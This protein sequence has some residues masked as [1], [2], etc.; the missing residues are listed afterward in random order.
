MYLTTAREIRS[1]SLT[2]RDFGLVQSAIP[3]AQGIAVDNED[4]FVF[5]AEKS[6]DKAGIFKSMLDGSAHQNVVSVGVETVEDLAVDWIGRHVYF[7]DSGRKHIVACDL[8]GTLCTVVISGQLGS[9]RAVAVYPENRLLFWTDWGSHPHIGSSG[10]DGSQRKEIISSSIAWPNGLVVDETIHRIFWSDGKLNRIESSRIDGSDRSVLAVTAYRPYSIDVFENTIYWTNPVD[11]EIHSCDKFNG[12]NHQL[13][14]KEASLTPTGIHINHPSK[15]RH[16]YNPCA[17][18]VCSHL[19][20]LSPGLQGFQCACPVGMQLNANNRTCDSGSQQPSVVIG[21]FTELYQI[22]HHQIGKESIIRLPTRETENIGALVFNPSG[23]SVIYSDLDR[24]VIFSMHLETQREKILFSD[25]S[26][27]E[28]L[29]VDPYTENVYWT[30]VERGILVVGKIDNGERLVLV[31]ELNS[32]KSV[33][34]APEKGLLFLVEGRISHVISSFHMDGGW[35]QELA[36]V[37]GTVSSM[38]YNNLN[39]YL[40]DSVRGTIERIGIDGRDRVILRS[41]LGSPIALGV[42]LESIFWLSQYSSR[43]NW[44][45]HKEPKATRGFIIDASDDYSVQYRKLAI[46][47]TYN[48]TEHVCMGHTGGCSDLC[49]PTPQGSRCLCPLGKELG[50]NKSVCQTA[51]CLGDQW[52]KC[53]NSC[54]PAQLRC[55]GIPD[56]SNGEDEERCGPANPTANATACGLYQ[57]AC[58]SGGCVP[59]SYVC[60]GDYDCHDHSDEPVTCP[61]KKC[62]VDEF[63]CSDGRHCVPRGVFCD[64]QRDCRDGS[65][66]PSNCSAQTRC[67]SSQ[68]HCKQ[69]RLCI[70]QIWVCDN[71]ADCEHAEDEQDCYDTHSKCPDNYIRCPSHADCLPRISLCSDGGMAGCQLLTDAQLC[72][73]AARN[74]SRDGRT[75]QDQV[76]VPPP[77]ETCPSNQFT[78]FL[79]TNECIPISQKCNC[80]FDCHFGEDE[81]GCAPCG[82]GLFRCPGEMRFINTSWV[83][84]GTPDCSSGADELPGLCKP[85]ERSVESRMAPEYDFCGENEFRCKSGQCISQNWTCDSSRDC[86]DGTDEGGKCGTACINNGKCPQVCV[87]GPDGPSCLCNPGFK[88]LD[89]GRQCEDIDECEENDPCSQ[90]CTNTKGSYKCSCAAG[91]V[92][93][94]DH[95]TCKVIE[96][97]PYWMISSA[98]HIDT[99]FNDHDSNQLL[100]SPLNIKDIAYHNKN[101]SL[102]YVTSEGVSVTS[103]TK[104]GSSLVYRFWD[105]SPSALALDEITGNIYVSGAVY[106]LPGQDRSVVKVFSPAASADLMIVKTTTLITDMAIDSRRGVLFWTEHVKPHSGRI[107]RS[108]MDG[109]QPRWLHSIEKIVYPVAVTLDIIKG[110]IYWA[111]LR[112]QS[113]SCSDY[114]GNHQRLVVS[115]TNGLPLS[116]SFFENKILWSNVDQNRIFS[117]ILNVNHGSISSTV[118]RISHILAV[119]SALELDLPNPCASGP[120]GNGLCLLKTSQTFTCFCPVGAGVVSLNPFQCQNGTMGLAQELSEGAGVTVASIL[121]CLSILTVLAILGWVYYKRWRRTDGSPLKFRFRNAFGLSEESAWEESID[122]SDRKMLF[123]KDE[124]HD[125]DPQPHLPVDQYDPN[126]LAGGQPDSAYAS[127]S[128]LVKVKSNDEIPR[129]LLPTSYS[130]KEQLLAID[131]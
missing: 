62:S 82:D 41:H 74:N 47:D 53:Q 121:I 33:T 38:V 59:S 43:I 1:I 45:T 108:L 44:I 7:T 11:H 79:G 91:Y 88:S 125:E 77:E 105:I 103:T 93:Q 37:Y 104:S 26:T 61:Q 69:S 36:Q 75:S 9:P 63:T 51:S 21:T 101:S 24:K 115:N 10:M 98:H 8:H 3:Q 128:S 100:Y 17:S 64:G 111:D 112:L 117:Q 34:L 50:S 96:G 67:S 5:W 116:L 60:D 2:R 49:A 28:G 6:N 4:K 20:L 46:V 58:A 31:R 23:H 107:N 56:C 110:R 83:C 122:Y 14:L 35:K 29:D 18:V 97:R 39:L 70:P 19:C 32:P 13:I 120:C 65:D 86:A 119:H 99:M 12:K 123:P 15:Q 114:N 127:H 40:S 92:L 95:R 89:N 106:S 84:D 68:F 81:E 130:T 72:A 27:V 87:P 90:I 78:C 80:E 113:I 76:P 126:R 55:D 54:I 85:V 109:T 102:Y 118:E 129:P 16:M 131:L 124:E 22:V 30:E 71:D 66:E 48:Y 57:F 42:G 94:Q 25:V 52:F 73:N